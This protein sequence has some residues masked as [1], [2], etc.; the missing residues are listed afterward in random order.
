MSKFVAVAAVA[1][2]VGAC[3]W[4]VGGKLSG[5]SIAMALGILFGILAGLP[6]ALLVIA[7]HAKQRRRGYEPPRRLQRGPAMDLLTCENCGQ[8]FRLINGTYHHHCASS[9]SGRTWRVV[10]TEVNHV[11]CQ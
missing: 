10:D 5:D 9:D 7:D 11:Q 4:Q 3:S 6:V 2:I 8:P 1:F